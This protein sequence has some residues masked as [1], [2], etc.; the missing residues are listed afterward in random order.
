MNIKTLVILAFIGFVTACSRP[1]DKLVGVWEYDNYAVDDS[2]VGFLIN[3]LPS[4]WKSTIDDYL[5]NAKGLTNSKLTFEADGTYKE[6]FSGAAEQFTTI[7]GTFSVTPEI[8]QI[9]LKNK[10]G[11]Q[12]MELIEFH[13]NYFVY[14]KDF[15]KFAIPLTLHVT[16]KRVK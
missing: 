4:D 1:E 12:V 6:S 14:K 8:T 9:N 3:M 5:E 7:I 2:G 11:E 16:Y 10:E 13:E 15:T